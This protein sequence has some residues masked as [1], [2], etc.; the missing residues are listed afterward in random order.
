MAP[1]NNILKDATNVNPFAAT[2]TNSNGSLK[3]RLPPQQSSSSSSIYYTQVAETPSHQNHHSGHISAVYAK[4]H[5]TT[6][7]HSVVRKFS[8][9]LLYSSTPDMDFPNNRD[10]NTITASHSN[11]F[12]PPSTPTNKY[13]MG[14]QDASSQTYVHNHNHNHNSELTNLLHIQNGSL[15]SPAFSSPQRPLITHSH[16]VSA[17]SN[18]DSGLLN[19][20]VTNSSSTSV[21]LTSNVVKPKKKAS[22][23]E[24]TPFDVNSEDKPPYSYATLIGMSILSHVDKR[25]TLS[26][27]YQWIADTFKYYKRDE[28]GWQNSIRHNLSLNKAFIKGEKSKDGKG[29]FWLIKNGCEEQ[30]LKTKSG[31]KSAFDEV[32]DQIKHNNYNHRELDTTLSTQTSLTSSITTSTSGG[33]TN[34][35]KKTQGSTIDTTKSSNS[36]SVSINLPS[37]PLPA[38]A[39]YRSSRKRAYD[40][41]DDDDDDLDNFDVTVADEVSTKK[42]IHTEDDEDN[43]FVIKRPRIDETSTANDESLHGGPLLA[44]KHLTITSSFSCDSNLELSPVR[45]NTGGPLLEPITPANSRLVHVNC[46]LQ[47]TP[48]FTNSQSLSASSSVSRLNDYFSGSS[49]IANS[50]L[51]AASL[52]TSISYT[53]QVQKTPTSSAHIHARTPI[54]TSLGSSLIRTP[55]RK[56][57][58]TL[59][60]KL[61]HNLPGYLDEFYYSPLISSSNLN[62]YDDDDMILRNFESP[63]RD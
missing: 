13:P 22:K 58:S 37:L 6:P 35:K 24:H 33:L 36:N 59:I 50:L 19:L 41:D 34:P 18:N 48:L 26:Q 52:N 20:S 49:S 61:W 5:I 12:F 17:P 21:S 62:L 14:I 32:M 23:K 15:L 38:S 16:K 54:S 1:Y 7:P 3:H 45:I 9:V 47:R 2:S 40:D 53:S 63:K 42:D 8:D 29:H 28:V 51:T 39:E 31:R 25:L 57:P 10:S 27:I 55:L 60:K 30:F 4:K 11:A 46:L 56:T 44:S 43:T